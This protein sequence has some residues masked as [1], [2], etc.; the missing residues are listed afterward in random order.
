MSLAVPLYT[1]MSVEVPDMGSVTVPWM[2]CSSAKTQ[3]S[4]GI[5]SAF[6]SVYADRLCLRDIGA[7]LDHIDQNMKNE[8]IGS[9]IAVM[10]GSCKCSPPH[11]FL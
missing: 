4:K 8:L 7:L 10:G 11:P 5:R 3:S 9:R 2:T 1:L 6:L